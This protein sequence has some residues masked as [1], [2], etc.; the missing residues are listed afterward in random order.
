MSSIYTVI[1]LMSGTSM[2]G[3]DAA[4]LRTD[5]EAHVEPLGFVTLPY[6]P[7][8][9]DDLGMC[10]GRKEDPDGLVRRAEEQI[11]LA[12]ADAVRELMAEM[13]IGPQQV[14]MIGFH[15][16]TITHDPAASFTWQLGNGSLLARETGISVV[17]DFRAADMAAG[18]EG[19]PLMPLYHRARA[20]AHKLDGP[21]AILN[22]GGVGNVTWIGPEE[23]DILAFDT[24]PGNAPIDDYMRNMVG[25][26]FDR[27]GEMASKGNV[28]EDI[29]QGWLS[30]PFF[31]R[32]PPKSLDRNAWNLRDARRLS[33]PDAVATMTAFTIHSIRK[34]Q[35]HFPAPVRQW[36]VAGGGR[37][38]KVI[39]HGLEAAL[40]GAV[41][42]VDDIGWNGDALEAE[43]FGYL[44]VRSRLGLPLSLPTTTGCRAPTTGG[45]TYQAA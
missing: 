33:E 38:N 30:G 20:R 28:H 40:D 5:G 25:K 2:D 41:K 14:D 23:G 15:G 12:H 19:A 26:P 6:D 34:A 44:A 43:G 4:L 18:G 27:H 31:M 17:N 1:G 22:I 37:K 21:L 36:L 29:L 39:L 35:Q 7:D 8:L 45:R 9:R 10:L 32:K 3:I 24:G 16:Q 13:E 11:T 42:T